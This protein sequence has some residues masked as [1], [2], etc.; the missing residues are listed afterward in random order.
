[1][2]LSDLRQ[3]IRCSFKE[4]MQVPTNIWKFLSVQLIIDGYYKILWFS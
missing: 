4:K 1:M 2:Y 3:F